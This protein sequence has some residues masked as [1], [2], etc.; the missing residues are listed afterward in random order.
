VRLSFTGTGDVRRARLLS[1]D[2]QELS[3]RYH[4]RGPTPDSRR[5]GGSP[6]L[7]GVSVVQPALPPELY[8]LRL[9]MGDRTDRTIPVQVAPGRVTDV[10]VD[11]GR[12]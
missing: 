1:S 10:E 12:L 8:L 2:E 5:V 6:E 9:R 11:L 4:S 3:V 7:S